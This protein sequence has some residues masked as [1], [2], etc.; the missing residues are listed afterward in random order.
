MKAR[1][2]VL[3]A[4]AALAAGLS[5]IAAPPASAALHDC[6]WGKVC[7]WNDAGFTGDLSWSRPGIGLMNISARNNDKLSSIWNNSGW[8]AA[9]YDHAGGGGACL[10]VA[11]GQRFHYVGDWINDRVSSWKTNGGC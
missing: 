6:P 11:P 2:R 7:F 9:F 5:G 3:A 8:A 4:G 1:F 10:T